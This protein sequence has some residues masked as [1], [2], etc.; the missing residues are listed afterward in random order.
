VLCFLLSATA[1]ANHGLAWVHATSEKRK[2]S[3]KVRKLA[4][5]EAL[6][7]LRKAETAD[8]CLDIIS[9]FLRQKLRE[10]NLGIEKGVLI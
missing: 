7:R 3:N 9:C 8:T 4:S 6:P 2:N 10:F 5:E 1:R